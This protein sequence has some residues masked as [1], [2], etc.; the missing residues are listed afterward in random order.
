MGAKTTGPGASGPVRGTAVRRAL[1]A[2]TTSIAAILALAPVHALGATAPKVQDRVGVA[3]GWRDMEKI[4]L[5]FS[6]P[7]FCRQPPESQAGSGCEAGEDPLVSPPSQDVVLDVVALVP[8]GF[9]PAPQTLG[10]KVAGQCAGHPRTID[11]SREWGPGNE[12]IPFPA[13]SLVLEGEADD[14][15]IWW[16]VDLVFVY[17]E[18][19]W[20]E[21]AHEKEMEAVE[22]A[23]EAGEPISEDVPTNVFV[24]FFAPD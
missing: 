9:T 24:Y 5:F 20:E 3:E 8:V 15:S 7:A 16:H 11:L 2:V 1:I 6:R 22:E 14:R 4:P 21:L 18:E 19:L 13:H 12:N 17:E 10:C 23:Q